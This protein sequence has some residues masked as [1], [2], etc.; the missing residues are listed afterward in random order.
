MITIKGDI[1]FYGCSKSAFGMH[2]RF[3]NPCCQCGVQFCDPPPHLNVV[4]DFVTPAPCILWSHTYDRLT[5][6]MQ[7]VVNTTITSRKITYLTKMVVL[8]WGEQ[9][10]SHEKCWKN[11]SKTS[12]IWCQM[13]SDFMTN[14][15]PPLIRLCCKIMNP[16]PLD[17]DPKS[18]PPNP[19]T[20]NDCPLQCAFDLK[21]FFF[22]WSW[23]KMLKTWIHTHIVGNCLDVSAF[24]DQ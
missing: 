24:E 19:P 9:E 17:H 20:E 15:S 10:F 12:E 18:W 7:I 13:K 2:I 21:I 22:K 11:R 16:S 1:I 23:S 3:H 5:M 6:C 8:N 14:P 4:H